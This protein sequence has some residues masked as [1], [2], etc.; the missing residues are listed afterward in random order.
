MYPWM[1]LGKRFGQ[2]P[3]KDRLRIVWL[4]IRGEAIP[5]VKKLSD[6]NAELKNELSSR[7]EDS[8]LKITT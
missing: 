8:N 3:V 1:Y 6:E 7:L 5:E 4:A 2:A